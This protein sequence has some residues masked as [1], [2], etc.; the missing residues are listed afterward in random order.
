MHHK[1]ITVRTGS[2]NRDTR[3]R[4]R[5]KHAKSIAIRTGSKERDKRVRN[6]TIG[7]PVTIGKN[8]E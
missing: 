3:V 2:K 4:N 8:R 6:R 7:I 1:N 5:M